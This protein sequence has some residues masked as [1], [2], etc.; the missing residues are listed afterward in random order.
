MQTIYKS[1]PY[2]FRIFFSVQTL[3]IS[4]AIKPIIVSEFKRKNFGYFIKEHQIKCLFR[5]MFKRHLDI[6]LKFSINSINII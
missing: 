2:M 1:K 6:L 4:E 3:L 5:R